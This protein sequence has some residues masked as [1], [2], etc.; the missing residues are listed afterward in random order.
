[1][2]LLYRAQVV[3][4]MALGVFLLLGCGTAANEE[5]VVGGAQAIP[6]KEDIPNFRSQGEYEL[7]RA[8]QAKKNRP[9]GKGKA[10]VVSKGRPS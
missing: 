6:Q 5:N 10:K 9:A 7:W 3:P 1:M 4:K 8:Q 2:K